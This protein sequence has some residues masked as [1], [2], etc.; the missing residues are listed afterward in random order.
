MYDD[1][2]F[3]LTGGGGGGGGQHRKNKQHCEYLYLYNVVHSFQKQ[4][5]KQ[6]MV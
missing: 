2:L 3:R 1:V 4:E 5:E 6:K